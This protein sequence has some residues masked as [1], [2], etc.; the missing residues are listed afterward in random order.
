[1]SCFLESSLHTITPILTVAMITYSCV[2]MYFSK[3][4]HINQLLIG[5]SQNKKKKTIIYPGDDQKQMK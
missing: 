3:T 2:K 1:M 4:K 5:T